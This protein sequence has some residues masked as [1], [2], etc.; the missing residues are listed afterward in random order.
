METVITV[1]H[2]KCI[3]LIRD[4]DRIAEKAAKYLHKAINGNIF[5]S[6]VWRKT[7][8][9]N[10]AKSYNSKWRKKVR[11]HL[12]PNNVL[13]DVHS[14][15]IEHSSEL[16]YGITLEENFLSRG[17]RSR[18]YNV[19]KGD[20]TNDIIFEAYNKNV[21][22]I[23]LEFNESLTDDQLKRVVEDIKPLFLFR[24][25]KNDVVINDIKV[26]IIVVFIIIILLLLLVVINNL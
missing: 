10:R 6:N 13:I 20:K 3:L 14:F 7:L 22:A 1:P 23:L 15:P 5:I 16:M 11:K 24:E 21:P 9:L 19:V 4:C 26:I 18:G 8:D 17:I 25:K 2:A 12:N